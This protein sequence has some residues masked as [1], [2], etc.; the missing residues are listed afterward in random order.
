MAKDAVRAEARGAATP[1]WWEDA[2]ECTEMPP[3]PGLHRFDV[4]PRRI[5]FDVGD[6]TARELAER[7][8]AVAAMDPRQS[9]E[10]EAVISAVPGLTGGSTKLVSVGVRLE[11]L[12]STLWGGGEVAYVVA[13]PHSVPDACIAATELALRAPWLVLGGVALADALIPLVDTRPHAIV[14]RGRV[15]LVVNGFGGVTIKTGAS[16]EE[17]SP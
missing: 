6:A 14:A 3:L 8:L 15:G 17:T 11:S 2:G 13:L 10:A 5:L 9:A 16:G 7:L 12:N 1:G 4:G